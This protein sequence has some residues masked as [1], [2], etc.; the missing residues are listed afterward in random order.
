MKKSFLLFVM[1][2]AVVAAQA[3]Q[4]TPSPSVPPLPPGPL[5]NRTPEFCRWTIVTQPQAGGATGVQGGASRTTAKMVEPPQ[6][7]TFTK[8]GSIILEQDLLPNGQIQEVWNV[9]TVQA[10][11]RPGGSPPILGSAGGGDLDHVNFVK[12]DFAGL[13]WVSP[14]TY[15][16]TAAYQGRKCLVFQGQVMPLNSA[17]IT[18]ISMSE[19]SKQILANN[20]SKHPGVVNYQFDPKPYLVATMVYIDFDTRLPLAM[21][22]TKGD[23][24]QIRQYTYQAHA[25]TMLA[26]PPALSQAL[27]LQ[28]QRIKDL[29]MVAP[30]P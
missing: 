4:R 21:T 16:G 3:Q 8:T 30:A 22:F 9:G 1:L 20:R 15:V 5:L 10:T 2:S 11:I 12:S 14:Q 6:Q 13:D 18:Q 26:L 23:K 7:V 28:Q 27:S 17:E 19:E 25:A 29:S 24:L